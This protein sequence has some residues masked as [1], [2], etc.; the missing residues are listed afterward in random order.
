[1]LVAYTFFGLDA[2]SFHLEEPFADIPNGLAISAMAE[3]IEI[4]IREALGETNLPPM[5]KA[6]DFILM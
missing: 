5:P 3:T 1:V 2:L 4:N 6:R